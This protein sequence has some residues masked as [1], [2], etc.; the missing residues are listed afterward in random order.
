MR[1]IPVS[2]DTQCKNHVV[3]DQIT[4]SSQAQQEFAGDQVMDSNQV[5]IEL[6]QAKISGGR[7]VEQAAPTQLSYRTRSGRAV[8]PPERFGH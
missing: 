1:E 3:E 4:N 6:P 2:D 7:V 8:K 5:P